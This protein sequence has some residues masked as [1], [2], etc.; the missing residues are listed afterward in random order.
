MSVPFSGTSHSTHSETKES[1]QNDIPYLI[2][3]SY[4]Y[5]IRRTENKQCPPLIPI[6]TGGDFPAG[7]LKNFS[8]K[9]KNP[10]RRRGHNSVK[11]PGPG[12]TGGKHRARAILQS[13]IHFSS[14]PPTSPAARRRPLLPQLPH[15][16]DKPQQ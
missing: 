10:S 11:H 9:T 12:E 5:F 16:P 14:Q 3:T 1:I 8:E 2:G 6:L 15:T 7:K 13:G 4:L